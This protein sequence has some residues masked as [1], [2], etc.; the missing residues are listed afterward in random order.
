MKLLFC[1]KFLVCGI[2]LFG[3]QPV[4]P[5]LHPSRYDT[6]LCREYSEK[7]DYIKN[8]EGEL[9]MAL[10]SEIQDTTKL[11][12][13]RRK[14]IFILGKIDHP[15]SDRFLFENLTLFLPDKEEDSLNAFPCHSALRSKSNFSVLLQLIEYLSV[16]RERHELLMVRDLIQA[17]ILNLKIDPEWVMKQ[18][19]YVNENSCI[20]KNL[21]KIPQ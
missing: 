21:E 15:L 12:V 7:W 16:C 10:I 4:P 9:I 3:Q 6:L 8:L 13:T 11:P 19:K 2:F 20:F 1:I 18:K 17:Y 14:L 5:P